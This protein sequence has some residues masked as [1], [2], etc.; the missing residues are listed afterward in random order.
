M[1]RAMATT[2]EYAMQ[3]E[4]SDGTGE[5]DFNRLLGSRVRVVG[6]Q[7]RP[8]FNGKV[9]RVYSFDNEKGRAGVHLDND[10]GPGLWV[11]PSN[12]VEM[13]DARREEEPAPEQHAPA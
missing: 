6:L 1:T 9:G 13:V 10:D 5:S 4:W 11:K 2:R 8:E 3:V 12:L 7:A